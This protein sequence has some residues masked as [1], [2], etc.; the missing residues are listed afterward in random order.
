MKGDRKNKISASKNY[1]KEKQYLK[2]QS[3]TKMD[4]Y[5]AVVC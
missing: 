3:Q 1:G 5:Y 2:C 4:F